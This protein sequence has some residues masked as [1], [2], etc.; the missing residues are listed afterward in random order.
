M[1]KRAMHFYIIKVNTDNAKGIKTN[2]SILTIH[3]H[4]NINFIHCGRVRA[5]NYCKS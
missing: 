1:H 5:F 4:I 3:F 2:F